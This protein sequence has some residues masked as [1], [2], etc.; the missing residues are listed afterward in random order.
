LNKYF[1]NDLLMVLVAAAIVISIKAVGIV[2]ISAM[3]IIPASTAVLLTDRLHKVIFL[4]MGIG[5]ISAVLGAFLSFIAHN[6]PTGPFMVISGAAMFI[7]AFLFAPE[8]GIIP[9]WR[10]HR[11][12]SVH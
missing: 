11:S 7:I 2:L 12:V 4:A 1:I 3:L 10:A 8:K 9:R 6:L 5:L